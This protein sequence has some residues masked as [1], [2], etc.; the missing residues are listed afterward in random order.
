M[1]DS[2]TCE[3]DPLYGRWISL[4]CPGN[5]RYSTTD[6][7]PHPHG[8]LCALLRDH[9]VYV[10][11]REGNTDIGII[12]TEYMRTERN[13]CKIGKSDIMSL[14][15]RQQLC[16]GEKSLQKKDPCKGLFLTIVPE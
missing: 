4:C 6:L 10:L 3:S 5:L 7:A 8:A 15:I 14:L 16:G 12:R 11:E 1:A 2:L 9:L 13:F